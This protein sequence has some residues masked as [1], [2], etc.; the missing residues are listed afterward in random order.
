MQ[1]FLPF[2]LS[3][4]ICN[5]NV[6]NQTM[7]SQ[8]KMFV[9]KAKAIQKFC[10]GVLPNIMYNRKTVDFQ[11]FKQIFTKCIYG[12]ILF[13]IYNITKLNLFSKLTVKHEP[14]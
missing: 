13:I 11:Y 10:F 6:D 9:F 4:I 5:V 14:Q 1:Y 12:K 2:M 3:K 8:F 7:N